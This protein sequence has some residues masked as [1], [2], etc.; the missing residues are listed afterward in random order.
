MKELISNTRKEIGVRTLRCGLIYFKDK[1]GEKELERF[2][3][4]IGLSLNYLNDENNW[5][6]VDHMSKFWEELIKYSGNPNAPFEAG[7]YASRKEVYGFLHTIF[8]VFATP[9]FIYKQIVNLMPKYNIVGKFIIEKISRN[10]LVI[11]YHPIKKYKFNKYVCTNR[12]GQLASV[13]QVWEMP[14]AKIN[15][16]QCILDGAPYCR[17]ELSWV[18]KAGRL[19]TYI[20]FLISILISIG[21]I[22]IV[23]YSVQNLIISFFIITLIT[24][25]GNKIDDKKTL[26]ANTKIVKDQNADL[27]RSV[28]I[29]EQKY[30]E[31]QYAYTELNKHKNHLENLVQQR[32]AQLRE[33]EAQ[34]VHSE[35]LASIGMLAAGVAHEI[36]TPLSSIDGTLYTV[37]KNLEKVAK[38]EEKMEDVYPKLK[39]TIKS[40]DYWLDRCRNIINSLLQFSRKDR[41]GKN[42]VNIHDGIENTLT[43]MAGEI[44]DK[45]KMNKH[46]SEVPSVEVDLGE[47]NQVFMNIIRNSVDTFRD[48][49]VK[50]AEINIHTSNANDR[51]KIIIEDNAGG[52]DEK[53]LGKIF[54]PFFTTKRVGDGTGLGLNICYNIV[55]NHHGTIKAENRA[56]EKGMRFTI[57]LPIKQPREK[58]AT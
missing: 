50:N 22:A 28:E 43:M 18:N 54:D 11:Q 17:Y 31:L 23:G 33:A 41:E 26:G 40:S 42:I 46:F 58:M 37:R 2:V 56:E 13:P 57:T 38:K 48:R 3:S 10:N 8:T 39:E 12:L 24:L 45:V 55:K 25:I 9:S 51:V 15:E 47:L 7:T 44:R 35:K 53:I 36:N 14:I 34:L 1:Y 32:T 4:K 27:E 16:T 30:D 5:I 29:I 20:G 49:K 6:A 21:Y 19:F 52:I